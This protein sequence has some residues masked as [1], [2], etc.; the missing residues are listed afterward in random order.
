MSPKGRAYFVDGRTVLEGATRPSATIVRRG[1]GAILRIVGETSEK[2][3]IE[4]TVQ[5]RRVLDD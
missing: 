3:R 5:C 1:S 2:V 4:A